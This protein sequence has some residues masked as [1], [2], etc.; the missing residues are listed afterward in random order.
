MSITGSLPVRSGNPTTTAA[1][2]TEYTAGEDLVA[3]S[4]VCVGESDGKLYLAKADAWATMPAIGITT[5]VIAADETVSVYQIG[6]V[7]KVRREADFSY[8][9][10]VF[11]SK[12][13]AG[14]LTKVAPDGV[15]EIYQV[16]GQAQSVSDIVLNIQ[17]AI[18]IGV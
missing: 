8:D 3:K 2:V 6:K 16:I 9:D 14:K 10:I 12:D 15:G 4:A 1:P 13:T 11:V 5:L 7:P 17:E 18:E